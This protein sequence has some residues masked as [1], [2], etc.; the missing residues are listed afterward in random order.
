MRPVRPWLLCIYYGIKHL[1]GLSYQFLLSILGLLFL[2][3]LRHR[4]LYGEHWEHCMH[5]AKPLH[6]ALPHKVAH[7]DTK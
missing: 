6:R 3:P 2:H 7:A 4:L 5:S 1:C